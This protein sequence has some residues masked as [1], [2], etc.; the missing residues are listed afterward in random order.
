MDNKKRKNADKIVT[1]YYT[2]HDLKMLEQQIKM[3]EVGELEKEE[4]NKKINKLLRDKYR[5]E[6]RNSILELALSRLSKIQ[7]EVMK[8]RY[9]NKSDATVISEIVG[10][11]KDYVYVITHDVIH[12]KIIPELEKNELI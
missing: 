5:I 3:V 4:K 10:I 1:L 9:K 8:L 7:Q 6:Y 11:N 2:N 12:K